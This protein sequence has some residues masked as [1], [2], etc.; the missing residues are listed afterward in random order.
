ALSAC[1]QAI[2]SGYQAAMMAP[3]EILAEQHFETIKKISENLDIKVVLLT[4]STKAK[5]KEEIYN[6][7]SKGEV[8]LVV[9]THALI[10]EGVQFN[11]LGFVII[12]EQHR[13]GVKQRSALK[14]KGVMPD[15]LVMTATPIPRTL[16]M[17]V[18]G[19]LD[20]SIID[21]LPK[22]RKPVSTKIY[23]DKQR[24]KLYQGI[25]KELEN[26]RQVYVIYPLVEESE[27]IDLKNATD[28]S[29]HLTEVFGPKYLVSLLHGRMKGE[30]KERI[31]GEF[32]R[33]EVHILASTSVVEVGVDVPNATVMAI[34]HAERFG[35]SQLHQ[36]RGRV[37][38]SDIQSYCILMTNY[39]KSK[40]AMKRLDIMTKTND[41]FRIAEEDLAIRGPG[42]VLGARQSG[43]PDFELA[44]LARDVGVLKLARE[45]AMEIIQTDPLL[46]EPDNAYIRHS[47]MES[48]QER[49]KLADV[50]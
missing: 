26:G 35:L 6:Q 7:I 34:E 37:G 10:Q 28:M 13:F 39:K 41:G 43:L 19:D 48:W 32:K 30:E 44:N 17:T 23:T 29:E 47:F 25:Q 22:G 24:G 20:I 5:D 16:A 45:R 12:D 8:E 50:G 3:T 4:G 49:L 15:I 27:K 40:E 18:Y 36:L 11:R 46:K 21:E 2:G 33:G 1:W 9:G 42:E 14:E 38:R 31:M